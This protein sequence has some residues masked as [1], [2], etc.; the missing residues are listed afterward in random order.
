MCTEWQKLAWYQIRDSVLILDKTKSKTETQ[1]WFLT[2]PNPKPKLNFDSWKNQMQNQNSDLVPIK[3]KSGTCHFGTANPRRNRYSREPLVSCQVLGKTWI[4]SGPF[5]CW[6]LP[7]QPAQTKCFL[8]WISALRWQ[9]LS[10]CHAQKLWRNQ[11][12]VRW[13]SLN[14]T[15]F[16]Q[17]FGL[18]TW[19]QPGSSVISANDNERH[20][21]S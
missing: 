11:V 17:R 14:L 4:K 2:K 3:T 9:G 8:C 7:Q 10:R 13:R 1:F 20:Q 12:V 5:P 15:K 18:F 19:L 21:V 6:R 16:G